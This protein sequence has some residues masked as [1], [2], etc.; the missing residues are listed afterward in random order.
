MFYIYVYDLIW[1]TIIAKTL[2]VLTY[3]SWNNFIINS[4]HL[5]VSD[6]LADVKELWRKNLYHSRSWFLMRKEIKFISRQITMH[7]RLFKLI[8]YFA[9]EIGKAIILRCEALI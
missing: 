4:R 6:F 2:Y 1:Y 8:K 9:F 3:S 5:I 7:L